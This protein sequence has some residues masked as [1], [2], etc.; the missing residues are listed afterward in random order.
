MEKLWHCHVWISVRHCL[1]VYFNACVIFSGNNDYLGRRLQM[2][3]RSTVIVPDFST[4]AIESTTNL[5][6]L[7]IAGQLLLRS[8]RNVISHSLNFGKAR[9]STLLS[10]IR[11][12]IYVSKMKENF[13]V[14]LWPPYEL[15]SLSTVW[16]FVSFSFDIKTYVPFCKTNTVCSC[17]LHVFAFHTKKDHRQPHPELTYFSSTTTHRKWNSR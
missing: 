13:I 11:D 12:C 7:L 5:G 8:L 16:T 15:F 3:T 10:V 1:S 2:W 4:L 14:S 17:I 9:F 6:W